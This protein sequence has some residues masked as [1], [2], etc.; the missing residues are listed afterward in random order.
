MVRASLLAGAWLCLMFAAAP[1]RAQML[2]GATA[3]GSAGRLY[4]LNPATGGIVQD[5]GP[6]NDVTGLNYPITGMAFHPTTSVL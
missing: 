4:V 2:Y 5:V 3:S 1:A 6:L